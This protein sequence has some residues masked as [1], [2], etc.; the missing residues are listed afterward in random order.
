MSATLIITAVGGTMISKSFLGV[1]YTTLLATTTLKD[2]AAMVKELEESGADVSALALSGFGKTGIDSVK[3]AGSFKIA[4]RLGSSKDL[5]SLEKT[6]EEADTDLF[7]DFDAVTFSKSGGGLSS[8]F[9][10]AVR[11]NRKRAKV[12]DYNIA[13]LGRETDSAYSLTARDKLTYITNKI[14]KKADDMPGIGLSSLSNTAYSDYTDKSS[15]LYYAKSGMTEQVSEII[16]NV[17]KSGKKFMSSE[18]NAYAA[19]KSDVI[20]NSPARSNAA[21]I[22]DD[23]IPFYQMALRGRTALSTESLNL[24]TDREEELLKAVEGGMGLAYTLTAKYDTKL[25][26]SGVPVFY[27]SLYSDL[28]DGI[29]SD[30]KTLSELYGKI[31]NSAIKSHK[32]HGSGLRETV[33]ENGVTVFVNYSSGELNSPAGSVRAHG[34]LIWEEK[35]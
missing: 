4:G 24:A 17:K 26:D 8:Y 27:N 13:L 7:L 12:Y 15:G 5:K 28:K 18:A 16:E 29:V 14:I 25:I 10:S 6:C 31:G 32:I 11:A 34:F 2:A 19:V 30:S 23:D 22:F 35:V 9:D 33:Y 20:F 21:L 3:P 1:P